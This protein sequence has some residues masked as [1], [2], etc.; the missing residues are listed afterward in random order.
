MLHFSLFRGVWTD[1]LHRMRREANETN[2]TD[3]D[4]DIFPERDYRDKTSAELSEILKKMNEKYDIKDDMDIDNLDTNTTEYK[5]CEEIFNEFLISY[6]KSQQK[7]NAF[8]QAYKEVLE[9]E[10][11]Y[12]TQRPQKKSHKKAPVE[13]KDNETIVFAT[14][15]DFSI[16]KNNKSLPQ[17]WVE[18]PTKNEKNET[19][20]IIEL[21]DDVKNRTN[22]ITEYLKYAQKVKKELEKEKKN[23]TEDNT[24]EENKGNKTKEE[25]TTIYSKKWKE[26][27]ITVNKNETVMIL[28]KVDEKKKDSII[29]HEKPKHIDKKIPRKNTSEINPIEYDY[30]EQ[31]LEEALNKTDDFVDEE[32][33]N[34]D[35]EDILSMLHNI[36][37]RLKEVIPKDKQK[38]LE[39]QSNRIF[40]KLIGTTDR[41][42]TKEDLLNH[43]MKGFRKG[44]EKYTSDQREGKLEIPTTTPEH[45]ELDEMFKRFSKQL[46]NSDVWMKLIATTA[47]NNENVA[48]K[49]KKEESTTARGENINDML[50]EFTKKMK[51]SIPK[52]IQK[53]MM[54]Q[55]YHIVEKLLASTD[56]NKEHIQTKHRNEKKTTTPKVENINEKK[57]D[58]TNAQ[59]QFFEKFSKTMEKVIPRET[60]LEMMKESE[61]IIMKLLST[62]H[63]HGHKEH[64]NTESTTSRIEKIKN[65]LDSYMKNLFDRIPEE[66]KKKVID[67]SNKMHEHWRKERERGR[68]FIPWSSVTGKHFDYNKTMNYLLHNMTKL[69]DQ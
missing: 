21:L 12:G 9:E 2:T 40:T 1:H 25:A 65:T 35:S 52:E 38:K 18:T 27:P 60:Q 63:G 23:V 13:V 48:N 42:Q 29:E 58:N 56:A 26:I 19:V 37:K 36:G 68:T 34:D 14:D 57:K 15:L 47:S 32:K 46:N 49:K 33:K 44:L 24:D 55:S 20:M 61:K 28:T 22:N 54:D 7:H 51:E 66:T 67:Q 43:F 62:T 16:H 50:N 39:E 6:N 31:I 4:E 8:D 41:I 17:K 5:E 69:F 53:E 11:K 59:N 10:E 30:Y 64:I 45:Q 3:N